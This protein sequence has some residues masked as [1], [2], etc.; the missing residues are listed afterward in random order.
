MS[1]TRICES[2]G[3]EFEVSHEKQLYCSK[4]CRRRAQNARYKGRTFDE[5]N[6]CT[7]ENDVPTIIPKEVC[8][9]A[10]KD[11]YTPDNKTPT[12]LDDEDSEVYYGGDNALMAHDYT[13]LSEHPSPEE[14]LS[15]TLKI[16]GEPLS[17][18]DNKKVPPPPITAE[19]LKQYVEEEFS[20]LFER[21]NKLQWSVDELKEYTQPEDDDV[22]DNFYECLQRGQSEYLSTVDSIRK[23]DL[24]DI[25]RFILQQRVVYAN[26]ISIT[27]SGN[28]RK[29][30]S[31]INDGAETKD[32]IDSIPKLSEEMADN[33]V[34]IE[35]L[36]EELNGL[37]SDIANAVN[38]LQEMIDT[39]AK[40][41]DDLNSL[42]AHYKRFR[43]DT[44]KIV[45]NLLEKVRPIVKAYE[46]ENDVKIN[47]KT[48]NE[49]FRE[50][51]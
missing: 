30:E 2:C 41:S 33:Q 7:H 21:L 38:Q 25:R 6:V 36:S 5:N 40:Q 37:K 49:D 44:I 50:N 32:A 51:N 47:N 19:L 34:A 45:N 39:T 22:F 24:Q 26:L 10:K 23:A 12:I 16:V 48:E 35:K 4:K 8:T 43:T 46:S 31:L 18:D 20:R 1:E 27:I 17:N 29:F 3:K 14:D 28:L 15:S 11:V 9:L 42:S 13:D